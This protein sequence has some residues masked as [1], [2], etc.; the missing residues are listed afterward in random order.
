MHD[1]LRQ[2]RGLPVLREKCHLT[3]L[4]SRLLENF[5]APAPRGFLT[6]V[7]FPQVQHLPLDHLS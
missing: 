4:A 2:F 3:R 1:F 7:D 6:A 5:N